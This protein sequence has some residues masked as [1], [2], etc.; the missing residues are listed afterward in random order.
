VPHRQLGGFTLAVF[1]SKRGIDYLWGRV[2][3]LSTHDDLDL[4]ARCG[5]VEWSDTWRAQMQQRLF[6][7]LERPIVVIVRRRFFGLGVYACVEIEGKARRE[8]IGSPPAGYSGDE[9]TSLLVSE[10]LGATFPVPIDNWRKW[11]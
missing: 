8:F 5:R 2:A 10:P 4:A 6:A 1:A 9:T 11:Q 7:E 3:D